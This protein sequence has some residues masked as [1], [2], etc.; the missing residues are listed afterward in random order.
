MVSTNSSQ[1]KDRPKKPR[2]FYGWWM[3]LA[4][5][6]CTLV[7]SGCGVYGFSLFVTPLEADFGWN[8]A[9]IATA[10]TFYMLIA[11]VTAPAIGR[12]MHR[13]G[14]QKVIAA[15]AALSGLSFLL[16]NH[17]TSLSVYY[18]GWAMFGVGNSAVGSVPASY[19]VS[20][21]FKKRRGMVIGIMSTGTGAG[22]LILSPIIG[23]YLIPT[24]GW[25][26]AYLGM[27][28]L[29]LLPL[30]LGLFL[31]RTKPEDMGLHPD[32]IQDNETDTQH[33][34][35]PA[36]PEGLSLRTALRTSALWLTA[37]AFLTSGFG[38]M[39]ALQSQAPHLQDI[40]FPLAAAATALSSVGL[41]STIGKFAFGSLFDRIK[42]K[43]GCCIGFA[44]QLIAVIILINITATSPVIMIWLYA[45][46]MGL[47]MGSWL[48][49]MSMLVSTDFGLASYGAIFGITY[50][51][52]E[53]GNAVGPLIAGHM[54]DVMHTY[55]Q[56][57]IIFAISCA[58]AIPVILLTRSPKRKD[59]ALRN[60]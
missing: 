44:L 11:G 39:G 3:V 57:F 43:Y 51:A 19:V 35:G 12:M 45:I 25:R 29:M 27:A 15:G 33:K 56:I 22:G 34:S 4:G 7:T 49:A 52:Q 50:M 47:G 31:V 32:G 17:V 46:S 58:V 24:F 10:F 8:R 30:F 14:A 1:N 41:G 21:W 53:I 38:Y 55:H 18:A 6:L 59:A 42:P 20:N 28:I 40:G 5:F 9:A 13:F 26:T 36:T 54:Y 2:I 60:D 16:L 23:S 37:V 48:P